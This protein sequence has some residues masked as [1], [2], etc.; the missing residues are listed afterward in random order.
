ML[1]SHQYATLKSLLP[2]LV[3]CVIIASLVLPVLSFPQKATAAS[4][5][6]VKVSGGFSDT[7]TTTLDSPVTPGNTLVAVIQ[8]NQSVSSA[9]TDQ[10]DDFGSAIATFDNGFGQEAYYFLLTDVQSGAQSVTVTLSGNS[11]SSL[12][13]VEVAGLV[14]AE[15]DFQDDQASAGSP[16]WPIP[17]E[18][19]ASDTVAIALFNLSVGRDLSATLGTILGLGGGTTDEWG[20]LYAVPLADP[21]AQTI[22]FTVTPPSGVNANWSVIVLRGANEVPNARIIRLRG[23]VRIL[24]G[25]RF[26]GMSP[27]AP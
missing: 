1:R 27:I 15:L 17:V 10:S 8:S 7:F 19:T 3:L 18:P 12:F 20:G 9:L 11:L 22:Q 26:G 21:G 5:V 13:V 14:G 16:P 24:G 6:Q 23:N 25:V 2:S 4:V